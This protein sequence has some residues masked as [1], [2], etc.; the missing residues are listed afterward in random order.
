[1]APRY[2]K[3]RVAEVNAPANRANDL[4]REGVVMHGTF[5]ER[6]PKR[7]QLPEAVV[8]WTGFATSLAFASLPF[9][10]VTVAAILRF[11]SKVS[12]AKIVGVL[13][14]ATSVIPM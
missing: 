1:M 2:P 4:N 14:A 5:P 7:T 10:L 8:P 9:V 12:V 13:V 3:N 6:H 11:G